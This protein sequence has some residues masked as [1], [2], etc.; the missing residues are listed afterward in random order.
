[1]EKYVSLNVQPQW[2]NYIY[3]SDI[4]DRTYGKVFKVKN[5]QDNQFYAMKIYDLKTLIT[6]KPNNIST[7]MIRIFREINTFKL[8]HTNITKFY[9]SYFTNDD[10][11]V[12]ITELAETDL[13]KYREANS[14][15]SNEK[16]KEIMIQIMRG[17]NYLQ[18]QKIMHRDLS[19]EN[20]LMFDNAEKIKL[21]DFGLTKP[22]SESNED[23]D[24]K[25]FEAPEITTEQE[26]GYN[27]QVDIWQAGIILYYLCT[28]SYQYREKTLSIIKK[29]DPSIVIE[30]PEDRKVFEPLLNKILQFHPSQR[31][32]AL[33]IISDLKQLSVNYYDNPFQ[34]IN[35]YEEEKFQDVDL[36]VIRQDTFAVNLKS[37][38]EKVNQI[39]AQLGEFQYPAIHYV[40]PNPNRIFQNCIQI[41]KEDQYQGEIDSITKKPDGR[42]RKIYYSGAIAEGIWRDNYLN[43]YCRQIL[44]SGSY[45]LG[46]MKNTQ[47]C[48]YGKYY[49]HDGNYYEGYWENHKSHGLGM[50]RFKNGNYYFG[51]FINDFKQGVGVYTYQNGDIHLGQ[52]ENNQLH[53]VLMQILVNESEQIQV[54]RY[55]KNSFKQTLY[56]TDRKNE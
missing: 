43:G 47:R 26:Q 4:S 10:K 33:E 32:Q 3:E 45:Y 5:T 1:M 11:F 50:Q 52:F 20:I 8:C 41:G 6:R 36:S 49:F 22:N 37:P 2:D 28:G 24:N 54:R 48:G 42:G 18:S 51:N 38:I 35:T 56:K 27:N 16:I 29:K 30:L 21:F 34:K 9:E 25:Y 46:E 40:H 15:I 53:G 19:P 12:I 44:A 23:A 39:L 14:S 17:V 55:E 7:E 31:P 13:L